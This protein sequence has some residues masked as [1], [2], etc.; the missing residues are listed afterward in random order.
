MK[1][2]FIQIF[3]VNVLFTT[4]KTSILL[5]VS[6]F[7]RLVLLIFSGSKELRTCSILDILFDTM[8]LQVQRG[9]F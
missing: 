7:F 9:E 6:Q 3:N 4:N 5:V 2:F 8:N 1:R